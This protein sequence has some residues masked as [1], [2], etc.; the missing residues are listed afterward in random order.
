M[1]KGRYNDQDQDKT[2]ATVI[3]GTSRAERTV[4]T[5]ENYGGSTHVGSSNGGVWL[6]KTRK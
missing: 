4:F 1:V 3:R 2:V 6:G 5:L